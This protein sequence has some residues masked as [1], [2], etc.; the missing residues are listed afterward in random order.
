MEHPL[1]LYDF[2]DIYD[3]ILR[4]PAEQVEAE[5]RSI[6]QLLAQRGITG[7]HILELACGTCA[8][9]VLLAQQGFSVTGVD[10]SERMLEGARARAQEA[11]VQ[12]DLVHADIVDM[13]LGTQ[14][15]DC[16]IFMFETFPLVTAY[17]DLASHFH[18]VLQ[19]LSPGG[20]YI[21]DIDAHRHG[22][23][24]EH[25][26][27]GRRTVP[28]AN[29]W[30]EVWNEDFPGDWILGTRHMAM[31]CRIHMDE[32]VH[33]TVDEWHIRM[34]SLW[35]LEVLVKTLP[36]WRLDGFYSW[37]DLSQDIKHEDHVFM[38]LEAEGRDTQ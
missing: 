11:G 20:I 13:D 1:S 28:L 32:Q 35:N 30:V 27:W 31:H 5:V 10:L 22:V 29:G 21:I 7:G 38:V 18:R 9:G 37:R 24:A 12:I 19:H 26:I 17:E 14:M 6:R 33:E 23:G 34:D 4:A 2:P 36:G 16:A 3:Q 25:Q 15:F 8:H